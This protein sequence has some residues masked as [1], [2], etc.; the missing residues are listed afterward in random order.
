MPHPDGRVDPLADIETIETEL[1]LSDY[2]QAERRLHRVGKG[3]KSGDAEA[4]AER[5][6]LEKV[7]AA[8]AE[9]KPARSVPVP[10]AAAARARATCRR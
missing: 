5:D 1:I 6:W 8:L 4:I 9:G 7:V 2:E 10:D 3:A